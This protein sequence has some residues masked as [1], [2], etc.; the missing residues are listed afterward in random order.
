MEMMEVDSD[1][2]TETISFNVVSVGEWKTWPRDWADNIGIGLLKLM[3]AENKHF[4][5]LTCSGHH[6][7]V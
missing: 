2:E 1:D 3:M 5:H 6:M 7:I 4:R